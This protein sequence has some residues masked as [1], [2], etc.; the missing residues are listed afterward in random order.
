MT[1]ERFELEAREN[2]E[3]AIRGIGRD[4]F[5]ISKFEL[6]VGIEEDEGEYVAGIV[7]ISYDHFSTRHDY[8]IEVSWRDD[9]G[10]VE[11]EYGEDCTG[12]ISTKELL[13]IL[14]VSQIARPAAHQRP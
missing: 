1:N 2:L 7:T 5:K 10:E 14:F 12:V 9:V 4:D 8:H 13:F 3:A 6:A 11:F